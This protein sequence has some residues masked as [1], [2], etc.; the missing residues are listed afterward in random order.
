MRVTTRTHAIAVAF[1]SLP[2]LA[3]L[4]FS[5][6]FAWAGN[7]EMIV[8]G[9][10]LLPVVLYLIGLRWCRYIVGGLAAISF[11]LST[12]IPMI[13]GTEGKYFWLIWSPIW[14]T[15]GF[16]ALVSFIPPRETRDPAT[17]DAPSA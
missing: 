4:I 3:V 11:L 8:A 12:T 15:F 9:T 14:L 1:Y 13:R 6:L 5:M 7:M 2:F 16:A 10:A 17:T